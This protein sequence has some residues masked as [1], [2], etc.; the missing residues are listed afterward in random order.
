MVGREMISGLV[1]GVC[2][3]DYLPFFA[4]EKFDRL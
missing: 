1:R 3:G 4:S 2:W